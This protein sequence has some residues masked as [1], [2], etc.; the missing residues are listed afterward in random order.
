VVSASRAAPDAPFRIGGGGVGFPKYFAPAPFKPRWRVELLYSETV[1]FTAGASGVYGA[2][3]IFRLNSP[4]DPDYSGVGVYATNFPQLAN[5]Y[6]NYRVYGVNVDLMWTDPSADG[7][8][9]AA[10]I[11][12]SGG[13]FTLAGQSITLADRQN[14][15][16]TR[17][18]NNTGMQTV[19]MQRKF[20]INEID[21]ILPA[22]FMGNPG[23]TAAVTTNPSLTPYMRLAIACY[24]TATPTASCTVRLTFDVE[25]YN[26]AVLTA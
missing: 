6:N 22:E 26:R 21:G 3:K 1:S 14:I 10:C 5:I 20:R 8:N 23:Y 11:E 13:A 16:D 7:L 2:E 15:C 17:A 9:V 4:Y 24:T 12:P 18:L 19:R 25:F